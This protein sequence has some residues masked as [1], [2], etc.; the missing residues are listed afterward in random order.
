MIPN[1]HFHK[2][3]QRYIK[4]WFNQP[5]RKQ[6]RHLKRV[7]KAKKLAP[8][9]TQALRPIVN[10]P[11]LRYNNRFRLGKG[12]TIEELKQA[13][14]PKAQ[15]QTIGIAVD[16]RRKN[17]CV[18]SIQRNVQ[19]L[20]AYRSKMILFP[21]VPT[22]KHRAATRLK[23]RKRAA[24]KPKD[25]A[26]PRQP[27]QEAKEEKLQKGEA[28]LEERKLATQLIGAVMPLTA[29]TK[30]ARKLESARIPTQEEKDFEAK[31]YTRKVRA[32]HK[33][34]GKMEK[35]AKLKKEAKEKANK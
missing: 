2:D 19:R 24:R 14:I 1:G 35:K 3:W 10:C 8:R 29:K 17:K 23:S 11:T 26:Q 18:E 27:K 31:R 33:Y 21:V 28:T 7:E 6:R 32:D 15:A 20:K 5:M 12:F 13:K 9:P 25:P 34:K 30:S 22:A 4:L 16:K